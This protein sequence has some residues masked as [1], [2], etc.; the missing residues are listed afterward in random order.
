MVLYGTNRKGDNHYALHTIKSGYRKLSRG[1]SIKVLKRRTPLG[2]GLLLVIGSTPPKLLFSAKPPL[3]C[4]S[5]ER[6]IDIHRYLAPA[7]NSTSGKDETNDI[8]DGPCARHHLALPSQMV[9]WQPFVPHLCKSA[10]TCCL[11]RP[12]II[13]QAAWEI[14]IS[15][16]P[17][18]RQ[19]K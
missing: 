15:H 19:E 12:R 17:S 9:A 7:E 2:P 5:Q 16:Y 1:T 14:Q 6:N 18:D 13:I 3:A 8:P 4:R 10:S 11:I